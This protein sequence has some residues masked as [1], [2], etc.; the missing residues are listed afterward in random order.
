MHVMADTTGL[1]TI[2]HW[3]DALAAVHARIAQRFA[4]SEA[5]ER[6]K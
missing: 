4:R 1:T 2:E 5:R 3:P 6:A